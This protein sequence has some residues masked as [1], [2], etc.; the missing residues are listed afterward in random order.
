MACAIRFIAASPVARP[1]LRSRRFAHRTRVG[2]RASVGDEAKAND[3]SDKTAFFCDDTGVCSSADEEDASD[4]SR[5]LLGPDPI[6]AQTMLRVKDPKASRAFYEGKLGMKYLTF[7]DFPDLD[8]SLYFYAYT[9]VVRDTSTLSRTSPHDTERSPLTCI[10][11]ILL[12]SGRRTPRTTPRPSPSARS[13]C[14]SSGSPRW[15]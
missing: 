12:H 13:G 6:F 14:S 15:S 1:R 9:D 10:F 11:L 5:G 3:G 4:T 8:F 7:L 2:V